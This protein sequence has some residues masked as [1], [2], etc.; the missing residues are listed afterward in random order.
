VKQIFAEF[1]DICS[2]EIARVRERRHG[3]GV[4]VDRTEYRARVVARASFDAGTSTLR[5]DLAT[6][7]FTQYGAWTDVDGPGRAESPRRVLDI[8]PAGKA[9]ALRRVIAEIDAYVAGVQVGYRPDD[10]SDLSDQD[11][12]ARAEARGETVLPNPIDFY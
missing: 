2:Y 1:H 10:D 5:I 7:V 9:A 8:I 12:I 11:V 3:S 4:E 6:Q